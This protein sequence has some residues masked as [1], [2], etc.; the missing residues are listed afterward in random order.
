MQLSEFN[1]FFAD[2]APRHYAVR[3]FHRGFDMD[4]LGNVALP[5]VFAE[6]D[7]QT[8]EKS[9]GVDAVTLAFCVLDKPERTGGL[10]SAILDATREIADDLL[11]AIRAVPALRQLTCQSVAVL[12][13]GGT[14]GLTGWRYELEINVAKRAR[15]GLS[16]RF[17][18]AYQPPA[19]GDENPVPLPSLT[20]ANGLARVGNE[21]VARLG[22]GLALDGAGRI[23]A[24]GGTGEP[25]PTGPQG[26]IGPPGET[27]PQGPQGPAGA[28]G[29]QGPQGEVGPQGPQGNTGLQGPAGPTGADGADG[30]TGITGETGP[31]GPQG[32][33][34]DTGPQGPQGPTG[35]TGP[36]G[37]TGATG[38]Q[39]PAGPQ[40]PTGAAGA[41][42]PTGATGPA[43]ANGKTILTG[44]GNPSNFIGTDGDYYLDNSIESYPILWGPKTG[45]VWSTNA[46][47]VGPTGPTGATGRG[48]NPRGAWTA[49]TFYSVDDIVTYNGSTY[50]RTVA[51]TSGSVFNASN[52]DQ[53][54]AAGVS[55]G[56][57]KFLTLLC[58]ST[59]YSIGSTTSETLFVEVSI[60]GGTLLAG[61]HLF[62]NFIATGTSGTTQTLRMRVGTSATIASNTTVKS[63]AMGTTQA[64]LWGQLHCAIRG[65]T[66][67]FPYSTAITAPSVNTG[68]GTVLSGFDFTQT[69]KI[70]ITGAKS[71]TGDTFI[72]EA[73][74]L[75]AQLP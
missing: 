60:P 46:T 28:D 40:G 58:T 6:A 9:P 19:P 36:A 56:D 24:I 61:T 55:G 59:A 10:E 63:G 11:E 53:W 42:G 54:A 1:T 30:A 22:A 50:R 74:H 57:T 21:I 13:A 43:G 5:V 25:G 49:S 3:S 51:G 29:A 69:V 2:L 14:S 72:L 17:D 70:Q 20:A 7:V 15:G 32:P 47:L 65:T 34:G 8:V 38:P 48:F 27:G 52:W 75:F 37:A 23:T 12:G 33:Q 16:S 26:P 66:Q 39:G 18:P 62:G 68:G 31:M 73:I 41:T 35:A 45:G 44:T 4:E 67:I 71:A 64:G